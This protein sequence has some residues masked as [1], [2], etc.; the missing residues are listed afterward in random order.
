MELL[1]TP[2]ERFAGLPGWPF[3]PRYLEADGLRLHYVDEGK[4]RRCCSCTASRRGAI[5]T[6]R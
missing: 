1:R 5:S 4:G 2:D 6:G 3:T